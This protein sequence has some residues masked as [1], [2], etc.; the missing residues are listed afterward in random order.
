VLKPGGHDNQGFAMV[1]SDGVW[2]DP[3]DGLFKIWYLGDNRT[4]I[5][6]ATSTNGVDWVK[7]DI[8]DALVPNTNVVL[9]TAV[10]GDSSTVW[11]D[12]EETDPAKRFKAFYWWVRNGAHY[13]RTYFSP[14]GIH[15]GDEQFRVPVMSDRTTMFWNPFRKVWVKSMR[16]MITLPAAGARES[17]AVRS[18]FYSESPNLRTWNRP[19]PPDWRTMFWQAADRQDVI[20]PGSGGAYPQLYNLDS[21]AYESLMVGLFSMYYPDVQDNGLTGPNLVELNVGF[22][23]D[24]FHWERVRGAGPDGAF[25]PASNKE[26]AWNGFNTQSAGGCFLVVGDELW[27]YFSGRERSKPDSGVS[28]TGLARMRRDGFA[29]MDAGAAEGVLTTRPIRFRG[30]RL[31]VNINNP[32]GELRVE[33]LDRNGAVIEPF[34]KANSN[35]IRVDKTLQEVT[36][37]GGGD[38]TTLAGTPVRFRFYLTNGSLYSFWVTPDANG[39]SHGYVAAGGPGFAGA[40]DT[41]G[42]ADPGTAVQDVRLSPAGATY[43]TTVEVAMTTPTA[44]AVIYYTLDGST[45][46]EADFLYTQ[47]VLVPASLTLRAKAILNGAPSRV[48]SGAYVVRNPG[49]FP[50]APIRSRHHARSS[51]APRP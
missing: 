5:S 27:F 49:A 21:A 16:R 37:A 36:W 2:F 10:R 15:W 51:V 9:G 23:R 17:L 48:T 12:Q 13:M 29:S 14:D 50:A 7:P 39:A 8:P 32:N 47:P 11:L 34:S 30:G 28:S 6:Y 33:A 24:G 44:G 18:R 45:P 26:G 41:I 19:D 43:D 46:T 25:I 1:F 31:F 4:G 42:A 22:S 20:Y 40:T 35:P 38:L 3:A